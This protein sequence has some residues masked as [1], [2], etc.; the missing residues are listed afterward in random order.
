MYKIF[1]LVSFGIRF[2][3]PDKRQMIRVDKR[4]LALLFKEV[5]RG[6]CG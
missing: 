1:K 2:D 6:T 5:G 3:S 4:L